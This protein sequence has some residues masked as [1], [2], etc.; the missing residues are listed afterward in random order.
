MKKIFTLIAITITLTASAQRVADTKIVEDS[1]TILNKEWNKHID[2]LRSK[3]SIKQLID[4]LFDNVTVKQYNEAKFGE[5]YNFWIQYQMQLFLQ[6][7][8]QPKKINNHN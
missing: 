3:T 7:K 8:Q 5:L 2:S 1:A 6:R 4:F